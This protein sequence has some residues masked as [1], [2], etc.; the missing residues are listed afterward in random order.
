MN[1]IEQLKHITTIP[2]RDILALMT[3]REQDLKV[4]CEQVN[5]AMKDNDYESLQTLYNEQNTIYY[6]LSL[7]KKRIKIY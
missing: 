2:I 4:N 1:I 7:L 3:Q 6:E 5:D